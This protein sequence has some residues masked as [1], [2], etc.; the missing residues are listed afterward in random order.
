MQ[1]TK[2]S[3]HG[4]H[5]FDR[6]LVV[7]DDNPLNQELHEALPPREVEA[8]DAVCEGRCEGSD[9]V[10]E[11]LDL[12]VREVLGARAHRNI[13]RTCCACTSSTTTA[14]CG[15]CGE[16]TIA[17]P[18]GAEVKGKS[19]P[20]LTLCSLPLRVRSTILARSYSAMTPCICI[21]SRSSARSPIGR[22]TKCTSTPRFCSSSTRIC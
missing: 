14:P 19:C 1:P 11:V 21:R 7:L 16:R 6:H 4:Y 18:Y 20:V 22:S 15:A 2:T 10:G 12:V 13:A 17:Y 3:R 8:V 9:V 5:V